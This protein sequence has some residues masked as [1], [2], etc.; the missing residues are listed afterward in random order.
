MRIIELSL[1]LLSAVVAL[2]Y[3]CRLNLFRKA[4]RPWIRILHLS[5]AWSNLWSGYRIWIG[6]MD[7]SSVC[8]IVAALSWI[9][10]SYHT[11]KDGLPEHF[12]KPM[13]LD[14]ADY[15]HVVGRGDR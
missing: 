8:A 1:V 11:W 3:V 14:E 5:L 7:L 9:V 6:E 10:I 13:E 12:T 4:A 15:V 2:L